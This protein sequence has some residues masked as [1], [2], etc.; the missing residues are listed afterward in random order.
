MKQN[1]PA[2]EKLKNLQGNTLRIYPRALKHGKN[3]QHALM[4]V[5]HN[6]PTDISLIIF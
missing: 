2:A 6:A 3:H 1:A 4:V 5:G